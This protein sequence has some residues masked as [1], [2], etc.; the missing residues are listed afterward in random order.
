MTDIIFLICLWFKPH[1][2]N[3]I[4]FPLEVLYGFNVVSFIMIQNKGLSLHSEWVIF[5]ISYFDFV[6]EHKFECLRNPISNRVIVKCIFFGL[7]KCL[8][9]ID[10]VASE[11]LGS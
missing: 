3:K 8:L 11:L 9:L 6:M 2:E 4:L 7:E 10:L 5:Q 1:N